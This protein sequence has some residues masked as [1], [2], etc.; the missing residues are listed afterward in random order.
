MKPEDLKKPFSAAHLPF[1][2]NLATHALM[3]FTTMP[4]NKA[5][6][7]LH[8]F[9]IKLYQKVGSDSFLD[10][11]ALLRAGNPG[12]KHGK[13]ADYKDLH[14]VVLEETIK[15]LREDR[16][17]F[18]QIKRT[19]A[20]KNK[21]VRRS[22]DKESAKYIKQ[23]CDAI[24]EGISRP[25][26]PPQSPR[27][28]AID[29]TPSG[30]NAG[31]SFFS[32]PNIKIGNPLSALSGWF[33]AG[34]AG[35]ATSARR[36]P[37]TQSLR[38]TS[39]QSLPYQSADEA[40]VS[41]SPKKSK[42][43][44]LRSASSTS[45]HYSTAGEGEFLSTPTSKK[46]SSSGNPFSPLDEDQSTAFNWQL[47]PETTKKDRKNARRAFRRERAKSEERKIAAATAAREAE[48]AQKTRPLNYY[49]DFVPENDRQKMSA[50]GRIALNAKTNAIKAMRA[51][52]EMLESQLEQYQKG[53]KFLQGKVTD[54]NLENQIANIGKKAATTHKDSLQAE[55][56]SLRQQVADWESEEATTL[57]GSMVST[58]RPHSRGLTGNPDAQKDQSSR[59]HSASRKSLSKTRNTKS[60][61]DLKSPQSDSEEINRFVP[62]TQH[63]PTRVKPRRRSFRT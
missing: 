48:N 23:F 46:A 47:P 53:T 31:T 24:E 1:E 41:T 40:E 36:T 17:N 58:S 32:I 38:S 37:E 2:Q 6:K 25:K 63:S 26:T 60:M 19:L 5:R 20:S 33:S 34:N 28:V 57:Q 61:E 4:D 30:S 13:T 11:A 12:E 52:I 35:A 50:Q 59:N 22:A 7:E 8:D 56:N 10:S 9:L 44:S 39:S 15:I 27:A 62:G 49:T 14:P 54:L 29:Y 42:P 43:S 18:G 3:H 45:L 51:K 55:L 16:N 21:K